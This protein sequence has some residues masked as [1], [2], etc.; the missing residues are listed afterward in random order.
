MRAHCAGVAPECVERRTR[1][2]PGRFAQLVRGGEGASRPFGVSVDAR[3]AEFMRGCAIRVPTALT[4]QSRGS[5]QRMRETLG[6]S[7]ALPG[8]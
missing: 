7:A 1:E 5:A 6:R 2:L 4:C 8:T 3:W